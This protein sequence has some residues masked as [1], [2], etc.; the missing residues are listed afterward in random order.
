MAVYL[1]SNKRLVAAPPC[2]RPGR[3]VQSA[4]AD[5]N[6]LASEGTAVARRPRGEDKA[7]PI[8]AG[9]IRR[10]AICV[11]PQPEM[12]LWK[13]FSLLSSRQS[14]IPL[15]QSPSA[16]SRHPLTIRDRAATR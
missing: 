4:A 8:A 3:C 7:P 11:R 5:P 14:A 13:V 15:S 10:T 1:A 9:Y 16:A 2:A 6:F 12:R